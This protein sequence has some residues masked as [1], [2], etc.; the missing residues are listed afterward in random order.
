MLDWMHK[1]FL[2]PSVE[3]DRSEFLYHA[4]HI[5][6]IVAVLLGCIIFVWWGKKRA[7]QKQKDV[8][9]WIMFGLLLVFEAIKITTRIIHQ[10]ELI[11][12]VPMYFSTIMFWVVIVAIATKNQ[13]ML[14][15]AGMGG[16]L[17]GLGFFANPVV[18]FNAEVLRFSN[19][20]SIITHGIIMLVGVFLVALGYT[21]YKWK[22]SWSM[23]LFVVLVYIYSF[24]QNFVWDLGENYLYYSVNVLNVPY[25]LFL[26]LYIVAVIGYFVSYYAIYEYA[27]K[28]HKKIKN[29]TKET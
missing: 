2:E 6:T 27:H 8:F 16:I 17:A 1:F 29:V 22:Y 9:L 12:F 19:Y 3:L 4:P 11:D 28:E 5:I 7:T 25:W 20:Y 10:S 15:I 18:G 21:K 13:H 24:F 14:N 23:G 26:T